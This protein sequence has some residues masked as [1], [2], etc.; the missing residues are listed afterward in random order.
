MIMRDSQRNTLRSPDERAERARRRRCL[1]QPHV[2][3]Q[4]HE[5]GMRNRLLISEG[6]LGLLEGGAALPRLSV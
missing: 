2:T 6:A 3:R 4:L 5:S 1:L